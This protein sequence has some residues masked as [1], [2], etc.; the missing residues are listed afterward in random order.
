MKD[1]A[2]KKIRG[3]TQ[4]SLLICDADHGARTT[5][6]LT[7]KDDTL[8][9]KK[10]KA[11]EII[12][13]GQYLTNLPP[14]KF[15]DCITAN[16][17]NYNYGLHNV[18]G[19]LQVKVSD[20]LLCDEDG[21]SLN[22]A[23]HV[24][25]SL[26]SN[27]LVI[28]PAASEP[29]NRSGQ[30]LS[31]TDLL[32]VSDVSQKTINNTTLDNLYA[33]YIS[34]KVPHA[35]GSVGDIQFKGKQEFASNSSLNYDASTNTLNVQGRL[36]STVVS[37]KHRLGCEGAVYHN[38]TKIVDKQYNVSETDYTIICDAS[39]N[40]INIK[41]P[42]AQNNHGRVIIVKK[43]NSDKYKLNS[44]Q[45]TITCDEGQIDI[46][47]FCE[48]K[49]NYSSRTFQSDGENWWIIGTKGS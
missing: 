18:R 35:V 30:N 38:I 26:K 49:M 32:I 19:N 6:T 45:I 2:I 42:P 16:F 47:A 27:K 22:I 21:V 11:D 31:D 5:H 1:V 3:G 17:L 15:S 37:S 41:L 28:D 33:N 34:R 29:I 8:S 46:N 24:A 12:A 44:N 39:K 10:I 48:I 14:D 4:D 7:Y 25:L 23:P 13:S 36:K 40:K 9:A 43:A 20:G